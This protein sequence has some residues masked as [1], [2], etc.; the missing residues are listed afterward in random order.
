[1]IVLCFER[2]S[3]KYEIDLLSKCRCGLRQLLGR[4]SKMPIRLISPGRRP[5]V[6]SDGQPVSKAHTS[7]ERQ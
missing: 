7:S 5:E 4:N 3:R 6:E 2:N 1:M